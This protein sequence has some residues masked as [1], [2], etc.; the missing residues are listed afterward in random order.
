[1]MGLV[2]RVGRQ[3]L[4]VVLARSTGFCDWVCVEMTLQDRLNA[5]HFAITA[6]GTPPVS[7]SRDE[8]LD[9]AL[10]L[11]GLANA[12]NVTGGAGARP[13]LSALASALILVEAA[14]EPLLQVT[15][16]DHDR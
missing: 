13:H 12:V 2:A 8:L 14:L 1:M 5:G 6:E 16:R 11:K 9:K 10:P 4:T 15:C 3:C 7:A